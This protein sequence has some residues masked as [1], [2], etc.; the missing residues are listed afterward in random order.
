MFGEHV[1]WL[2]DDRISAINNLFDVRD[3]FRFYT[4]GAKYKANMLYSRRKLAFG[5]NG[6][7]Q[8]DNARG[9]TFN[10]WYKNYLIIK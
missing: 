7:L 10:L 3:R 2:A 8:R 6:G 1:D 5:C 9:T 4:V